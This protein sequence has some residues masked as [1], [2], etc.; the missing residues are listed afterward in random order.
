MTASVSP[1]NGLVEPRL[2]RHTQRRNEK[3]ESGN[4]TFVPLCP[5]DDHGAKR[6]NRGSARGRTTAFCQPYVQVTGRPDGTLSAAVRAVSP[7]VT[8]GDDRVPTGA[9]P[10]APATEKTAAFTF[11]SGVGLRH[12]PC[13]DPHLT[14]FGAETWT[15]LLGMTCHSDYS[16]LATNLDPVG[17]L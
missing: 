3:A 11:W 13:S 8:S 1:L 10:P 16:P 4:G 17:A 7:V 14:T 5:D 6:G 15:G 9:G 12:V 2:R